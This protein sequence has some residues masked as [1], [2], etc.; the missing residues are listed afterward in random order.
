MSGPAGYS[1]PISFPI[2]SNASPAASSRVEPMRW[3]TPG[4]GT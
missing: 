4:S 3:N 1:S 2:L